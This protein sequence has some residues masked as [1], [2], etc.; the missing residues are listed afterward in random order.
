MSK[1]K[2]HEE[3]QPPCLQVDLEDLL[4][5]PTVSSQH[6]TS[7]EQIFYTP[8]EVELA[9]ITLK[10]FTCL[11]LSCVFCVITLSISLLC[12]QSCST[13]RSEIIFVSEIVMDKLYI[14]LQLL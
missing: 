10:N 7:S 13:L 11:P 8:Y 2:A 4:R 1:T 6:R 14:S 3:L 9:M 12:I 5:E